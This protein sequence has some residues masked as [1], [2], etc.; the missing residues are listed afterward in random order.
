[1]KD[2]QAQIE[3]LRKD[4]AGC[5][6]IRDL[7]EGLKRLRYVLNVENVDQRVGAGGQVQHIAAIGEVGRDAGD[8]VEQR[9]RIVRALR[10]I[11]AVDV[12]H[13]VDGDRVDAVGETDKVV[14]RAEIDRMTEAL[15]RPSVQK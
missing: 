7:A 15:D 9:Q 14:A 13:V 1:M 12:L 2:Y 3:K 5:A 4:A 10:G 11:A 8:V 6:S